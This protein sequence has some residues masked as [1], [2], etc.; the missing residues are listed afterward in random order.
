MRTSPA[1]QPIKVA[2][3]RFHPEN[4]HQ[5]QR[6]KSYG[7]GQPPFKRGHG[8][9]RAGGLELGWWIHWVGVLFEVLQQWI[10]RHAARLMR[11][12]P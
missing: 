10:A 6:S 4:L 12:T 5:R 2:F 11:C 1:K 7:T 9:P 8:P 3:D